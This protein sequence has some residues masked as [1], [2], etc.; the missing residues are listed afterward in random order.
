MM[1]RLHVFLILSAG[2]I[3]AGCATEQPSPLNSRETVSLLVT[4]SRVPQEYMVEAKI[5]TVASS[6]RLP[7]RSLVPSTEITGLLSCSGHAD[8]LSAPRINVVAGDWAEVR[9]CSTNL[10]GEFFATAYVGGEEIT[11]THSPGIV[12]KVKVEPIAGEVVRARGILS[13]GSE[14]STGTLHNQRVVPFLAD[15][16]LGTPTTIFTKE[17]SSPNSKSAYLLTE[18]WELA[19]G[20]TTKSTLSPEAVRSAS[21]SER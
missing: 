21:P 8:V 5:T 20:T 10:P 4:R 7:P 13:L 3:F 6:T 12:F 17:H 2:S 14:G 19:D 11:V 16:T 15:C 9:V 1:K 18:E